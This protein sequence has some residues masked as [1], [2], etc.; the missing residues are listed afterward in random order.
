MA[1]A[2]QGGIDQS[3]E[4]IGYF[5]DRIDSRVLPEA[6]SMRLGAGGKQLEIESEAG[7][8][9]IVD[10]AARTSTWISGPDSVHQR[11]IRP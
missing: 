6:R 8:K 3:T 9:Y 2:I 10:L 7:G 11:Q 1:R 4:F 5:D